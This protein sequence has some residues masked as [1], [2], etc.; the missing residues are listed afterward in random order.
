MTMANEQLCTSL[1]WDA[2]S[3]IGAITGTGAAFFA[4]I[5]ATYTLIEARRAR[6]VTLSITL[7][8]RFGSSDMHKALA[9]LGRRRD[10]YKGDI[11]AMCDAYVATA[12]EAVKL[13]ELAEWDYCR[14]TVSKFFIAA[15]AQCEAGLLKPNV[16]AGQ[17]GRASI[18][19]YVQVVAS[20]DEVQAIRVQRR[21]DY[22][23]RRVRDFFSDFLARHFD[24]V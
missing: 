22:F 8:E 4:L 13:G 7:S 16:F 14:R 15:Y 5:I 23:D 20:L 6:R 10:E 1:S 2:L 3:A 12:E 17:I 9:Y 24:H 19:L 21:S 11:K 18:E